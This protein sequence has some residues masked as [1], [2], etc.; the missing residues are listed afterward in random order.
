MELVCRRHFFA[1]H[2]GLRELYQVFSVRGVQ[3]WS[4]YHDRID[5]TLSVNKTRWIPSVVDAEKYAIAFASV[6]K[7]KRKKKREGFSVITSP[8]SGFRVSELPASLASRP[9][10][11]IC[12]KGKAQ[13]PSKCLKK[14]K[15]RSVLILFFSRSGLSQNGR[16]M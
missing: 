14:R 4:Q 13:L 2:I 8:L 10:L 9:I 11:V 15:K 12:D 7:K 6:L 16:H 3:I 1:S 5:E